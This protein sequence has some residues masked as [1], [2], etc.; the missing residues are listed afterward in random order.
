MEIDG[1]GGRQTALKGADNTRSVAS[2]RVQA[3]SQRHGRMS[4][5]VAPSSAVPLALP[6]CGAA[7][8]LSTPRTR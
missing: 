6:V 8:Y 7:W 3:K 1:S 5:F 4:G 2:R